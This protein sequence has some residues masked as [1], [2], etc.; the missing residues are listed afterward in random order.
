MD[1][2]L[3]IAG[4]YTIIADAQINRNLSQTVTS[5]AQAK[6][7]A[8]DDMKRVESLADN[9]HEKEL[10]KR[11]ASNYQR[12]LDMFETQM[13]PK[14]AAIEKLP[15]ESKELAAEEEALRAFDDAIDKIREETL[16]PLGEIT[17][18][19][20]EENAK[21][22]E[23]YDSRST[24]AVRVVMALTAL[25]VLI[26]VLFTVITSRVITRPLAKGVAFA[27]G[28][29]RG[30]L[31][32]NLDIHQTD[33]LGVLAGALR[34]VG[35]AER[36]VAAIAV[37]MAQ[38][39]LE[40]LDVS[41]RSD[42]DVLLESIK[43]M[44]KAERFVA[45]MARKLSEG[46]LRVVVKPRSEEDS[47]LIS[48]KE[49]VERLNNVVMEVQ[50]GA[51][52]MAAGSEELS[53]S[54]QSLSQATTEQAAALEESSAS[55]EEMA[56][57]ISQNADNARQTEGI[58]VKAAGDARESGEA[59]I[60]TVAAMKEIAQKIS[61]IEEIA[62]QTD[63]LAL[64]AAIEAARAGEH[65][66]GFAV[67]AAE[68][69]KLAERSQQAA[70]EINTLSSSSTAVTE[71]TGA[72]LN[73][74]VPDIQKTAELV[75]E[76]SAASTEQNSGAIQVNKALQQLDQVVQQNASASEE[77]SSTAEELSSQAE[78][79]QS[80]ISFFQVEGGGQAPGRPLRRA[81]RSQQ[82]RIPAKTQPPKSKG[83]VVLSLGGEEE[84]DS[85]DFERF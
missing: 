31:E 73:R 57:S 11:F 58:A 45:D 66:K 9:A 44:L 62:R 36:E 47:L 16:A 71:S 35:D 25:A 18:S 33:E 4:I 55:M 76:I 65:G 54:A 20:A 68:V 48:L 79:L 14:L 7:S 39:E 46:D 83:G 12:Y 77:L 69:R 15:K 41:K 56:S 49:M 78:Q 3:R 67:V 74:L 61:I 32:Q 52:N 72:L 19:L 75:Q 23:E 6:N 51:S 59:M 1:T 70:A 2:S 30:D 64:N 60:Q 21:G 81:A 26:A 85:R 17:A 5:F 50:A 8:R 63:L 24:M 10:A 82:A 22:D 34:K 28:L 13:L 29:A 42:K 37:R 53:A 40:G 80:V 38:G 43:D 84:S 27:E